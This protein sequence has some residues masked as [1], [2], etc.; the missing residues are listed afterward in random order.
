[1]GG[2]KTFAASAPASVTFTKADIPN[3]WQSNFIAHRLLI[4]ILSSRD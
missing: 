4:E 3:A 2:K 1:M